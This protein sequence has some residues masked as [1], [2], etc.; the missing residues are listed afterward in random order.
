M[1]ETV[2]SGEA[3]QLAQL[4]GPRPAPPGFAVPEHV[5]ELV[6]EWPIKRRA[7][8]RRR[9]MVCEACGQQVFPITKGDRRYQYKVGQRDG[10]VLAH[11][12]QVHGWNRE[13]PDGE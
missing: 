1:A 5:W 7:D 12:I 13:G 11:L 9:D 4:R 8:D 3:R 2:M 6:R 10:L